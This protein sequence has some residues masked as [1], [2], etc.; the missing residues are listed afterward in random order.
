MNLLFQ[1][2]VIDII[3]EYFLIFGEEKREKICGAQII[4][5]KKKIEK[6]KYAKRAYEKH[7]KVWQ[8]RVDLL[9]ILRPWEEGSLKEKEAI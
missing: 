5:R 2:N 9:N 6:K 7:A 8:K 4:N 1:I 3:L